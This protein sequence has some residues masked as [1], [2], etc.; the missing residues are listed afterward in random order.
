MSFLYLDPIPVKCM[1]QG[2]CDLLRE[3]WSGS[4]S[5][6]R[7]RWIGC[8]RLGRPDLV[9]LK[10]KKKKKIVFVL[11]IVILPVVVAYLLY[12]FFP[13]CVHVPKVHC[14]K[15]YNYNCII[16]FRKKI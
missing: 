4:S 11:S 3:C 12:A 14:F 2:T 10:P 6:S 9:S 13:M 7:D 15:Q 1:W 16:F 5:S 8:L